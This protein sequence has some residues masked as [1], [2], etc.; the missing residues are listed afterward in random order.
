M[1]LVG[2]K[3]IENIRGATCISDAVFSTVQL[4]LVCVAKDSKVE[5]KLEYISIHLILWPTF[6]YFEISEP[7]AQKFIS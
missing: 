1:D 6:A 2:P 3:E 7:G 5:R 4:N